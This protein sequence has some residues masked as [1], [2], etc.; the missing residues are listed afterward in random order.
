MHALRLEVAKHYITVHDPPDVLARQVM[1]LKHDRGV[2]VSG[3]SIEALYLK[4]CGL[5]ACTISTIHPS[6]RISSC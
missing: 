3:N 4:R 1:A 5:E 6:A 2:Q